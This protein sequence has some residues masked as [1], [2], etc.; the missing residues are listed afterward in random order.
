MTLTEADRLIPAF[1]SATTPR[2][3]KRVAPIAHPTAVSIGALQISV[4]RIR[5]SNILQYRPQTPA[6]AVLSWSRVCVR[7][8]V[9]SPTVRPDPVTQG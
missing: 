3:Y 4:I 1:L 2:D 7:R 5:T 8:R 9:P 6:V